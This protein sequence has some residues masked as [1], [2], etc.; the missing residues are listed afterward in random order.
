MGSLPTKHCFSWGEER[1]AG[2]VVVRQEVTFPYCGVPGGWSEPQ[3][4][5]PGLSAA[6][7]WLHVPGQVWARAPALSLMELN[8]LLTE[9]MHL[10][11]QL[12][13]NTKSQEEDEC[14]PTVPLP[15]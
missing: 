3:Q 5:P 4:N 14:F 6:C 15:I 13:L 10:Q 9:Y 7:T 8:L 11:H 2:I 12:Q 1:L